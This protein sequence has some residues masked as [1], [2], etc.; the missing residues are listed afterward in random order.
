MG[1]HW[2]GILDYSIA[3]FSRTGAACDEIIQLVF[4]DG[5]LDVARV[6]L[7]GVSGLR[8]EIRDCD[9][10]ICQTS[11]TIGQHLLDLILKGQTEILT[12]ETLDNLQKLL[13]MLD[14]KI[15]FE[16]VAIAINLQSTMVIEEE[17][18][19]IISLPEEEVIQ[20][21]PP[22]RHRKKTTDNIYYCDNFPCKGQNVQ[23]MGLATFRKHTLT[24]HNCKPLA[25]PEAR[26]GCQFRA[27]DLTKLKNH[28]FGVHKDLYSTNVN[29]EICQKTFPSAHYL[30]THVRR[31]HETAAAERAQVCPHCGELKL[32]LADHIRRAHK[33]K[34]Y[35]CDLCPKSFK[36][37]VQK[38]IHQNVHTGFK[39]YT[40]AT[41]DQRF[42]RLHHRKVHLIK[43]N[44]SPGPVLKPP[45]YIDQRSVKTRRDKSEAE[46]EPNIIIEFTQE[47][48]Q[49]YLDHELK[50]DSEQLKHEIGVN[51]ADIIKNIALSTEDIEFD[52]TM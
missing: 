47:Q 2:T 11:V 40:C 42:A 23:F 16:S 9:L 12:A 45:D 49:E 48:G 1:T 18:N 44:H 37:N 39:P 22:K 33:V 3:D 10:I 51:C 29:C 25:C 35:F 28:M 21:P 43:Y 24:V 20:Q 32:Q 17:L 6:I 15:D 34:K 7:C 36:T 46:E 30:K 52:D 41:C 50:F 14:V 13:V 8:Q 38:R 4:E 31:M 5:C 19:T 26:H 27:D